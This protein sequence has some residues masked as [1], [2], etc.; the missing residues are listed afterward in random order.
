M[1]QPGDVIANTYHLLDFLGEGGMGSV[2]RARDLRNGRQVATKV[3]H[4]VLTDYQKHRV[5]EEFESISQIRHPNIVAGLDLGEWQG[6]VYLV[7]ELVEGLRLDQAI[8]TLKL[9]VEPEE[10]GGRNPWERAGRPLVQ[11]LKVLT[12]VHETLDKVH[13]DIKPAN[14][15]MDNEGQ[16]RLLDFGLARSLRGTAQWGADLGHRGPVGTIR[17]MPPEQA[18]GLPPDTRSDLFSFGVVAFEMLTGRRVFQAGDPRSLLEEQRRGPRRLQAIWPEAPSALNSLLQ[19]LMAFKREERPS[20]AREVLQLLADADLL[21]GEELPIPKVHPPAPPEVVLPH[22][23]RPAA[24]EE[25]GKA[26]STALSGRPQAVIVVGGEGMGKSDL[27]Y[28]EI[29]R[30]RAHGF[31]VV[32]SS[33]GRHRRDPE[34]VLKNVLTELLGCV[35]SHVDPAS[36]GRLLARAAREEGL[37][38]GSDDPLPPGVQDVQGVL[39]LLTEVAVRTPLAVVWDGLHQCSSATRVLVNSLLQAIAPLTA[40][41]PLLMLVAIRPG[42]DS[43]PLSSSIPSPFLSRLDLNPFDETALRDLF[44]AP[45]LQPQ[46]IH[47]ARVLMR[48]T[49]GVPADISRT[50]VNWVRQGGLVKSIEGLLLT[51]TWFTVI[52]RE[53][54]RDASP[55]LALDSGL[56]DSELT[57]GIQIA[58]LG[59]PAPLEFLHRALSMDPLEVNAIVADLLDRGIL[60][61]EDLAEGPT[62]RFTRAALPEDLLRSVEEPYRSNFHQEALTWLSRQPRHP[63]HG[64][65]LLA[66]QHHF[67]GNT[68]KAVHLFLEAAQEARDAS[69]RDHSLIYTQQAAEAAEKLPKN[70]PLRSSTLL[71]LAE[72][73]HAASHSAEALKILDQVDELEELPRPGMIHLQTAPLRGIILINADRQE[74]ATRLFKRAIAS[75]EQEGQSAL[76]YVA[77]ARMALAQIRAQQGR[78]GRSIELLEQAEKEFTAL[79]SRDGELRSRTNQGYVYYKRGDFN[80]ARAIYEGLLR[81][82]DR[83]GRWRA[84]ALCNLALVLECQGDWDRSISLQSEAAGIYDALGD[85]TFAAIARANTLLLRLRLGC[86]DLPG[87]SD[88]MAFARNSQNYRLLGVLYRARCLAGGEGGTWKFAE[89]DARLSMEAFAAAKMPPLVVMMRVQAALCLAG[90]ATPPRPEDVA[91]LPVALALEEARRAAIDSVWEGFPSTLRWQILAA[92]GQI[93]ELVGES[94]EARVHLKQANSCAL[95]VLSSYLPRHAS[96]S[97]VEAALSKTRDLVPLSWAVTLE[98]VLKDLEDRRSSPARDEEPDSEEEDTLTGEE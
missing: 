83:G 9:P 21:L 64:A 91:N 16:I 41:L 88:L 26:M 2:Y 96:E 72:E 98:D 6:E 63:I 7:M 38:P 67:L 85:L 24:E 74:E 80:S 84:T 56:T 65:A 43:W 66:R 39:R 3:L 49:C 60:T 15:M 12:D 97:E 35:G 5:L 52:Q 57:V 34:E 23:R 73:Y 32:G 22:L 58:A 59:R 53:E 13:R 68:K 69:N 77:G 29:G 40:S 31:T 42:K 89:R 87:F 25:I 44:A 48:R 19:R 37:K 20:S 62:Y 75:G 10:M 50:V 86:T 51:T 55:S 27:L 28:Q 70:S 33:G 11:L 90:L 8:P 4:K 81:S 36:Y 30:L 76:P 79:G 18:K 92:A 94:E 46:R 54:N 1:L 61:A 45:A 82:Q 78:Y 71:R 17:Y 95:E 47:V 93:A 14:I